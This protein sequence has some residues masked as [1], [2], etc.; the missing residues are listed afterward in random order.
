ML[1]WIHDNLISRMP[2]QASEWAARVDWLNDF[3]TYISAFCTIAITAVMIYFMWRYRRK[4]ETQQTEYITH[5]A[6]LETVWTVIPTIV[7]IFVFWYGF[8]VYHEQRTPPANAEEI[9]VEGYQWGWNFEYSTGKKGSGELV[10][11]L[12]KATRLVMR[13][14]DVTHSF[15]IPS[16]RVKEDVLASAYSYLWFTPIKTGEFPIFCTEYCGLSHSGMLAKLKVVE[17]E[18]FQDFIN[19]RSAEDLPPAELGKKLF[20]QKGCIGCHSVDGSAKV[21]PS[22]YQI[23]GHEV[24]FADGTKLVG[25]ENYLEESILNP[26]AKIVKGY[27]PNLMQSYKGQLEDKELAGLIAYIKSLK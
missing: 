5:N 9:L 17:P 27:P 15:F 22:L 21:C 19:E 2:V 23:F 7:C 10:V 12:G 20:T 14:K 16:M 26:N 11:P 13:S 18:V 4:S 25:D 6:L 8:E 3:I 1:Q 24:E